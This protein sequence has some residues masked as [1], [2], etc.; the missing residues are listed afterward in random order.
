[1]TLLLGYPDR[2]SVAGGEPIRFMVSCEDS[3]S[4]RA[5]L[6]RLVHGDP[7]PDGPGFR[8]EEV[9]S[10]V[11]GEHR[12]RVQPIPIGSYVDVDDPGGLLDLRESFTLFTFV[13]PTLPGRGEQAL[14]GRWGEGG[15]LL[16][17]DA[18]GRLVLRVG[19]E[20]AADEVA[21]TEPLA[22]RVWYAVAATLDASTGKAAVE[23]VP[24]VNSFSSLVGPIAAPAATAAEGTVGAPPAGDGRFLLAARGQADGTVTSHFNGKLDRPRVYAR[25]LERSELAALGRLEEPPGAAPVAAWDFAEGIGPAGI[26][27]DRVADTTPNGLDGTCVNLPA[28]AM[29]GVNWSG[30]EHCFR[31]AAEEYGAIHFHE[32]D[33]EDACWEADLEL[34]VEPELPSGVYAVRLRADEAEEHIP[35]CVRPPRGTA[36]A[37]VAMLLPTAS[38]M[39]YMNDHQGMVGDL[40]QL[41]LAHTPVLSDTDL[42]LNERRDLGLSMYDSHHDGSGSCYSTRLR[43]LLTMRPRYL[44]PVAS[45]PWGF[46]SDLYLIDWLTST[47]APFDVVTDEDLHH[48]GLELLSRYRCVLTGSH[49][50]YTSH[51]MLDAL[52]AYLL[53]GGR[54]MYLG[55]DGFYWVTEYHPEKPHVIE[56][57][58]GT[59]GIR[60]WEGQPGEGHLASTGGA[61]GLWR[62]HGRAPQKLV[63]VGFAAE[64]MDESSYFRR[65]PDSRDPRAAWVFEGV[66]GETFGDHGLIQGGASGLELDRYDLSLGTPPETLLLAYSEGHTDQYLRVVEEIPVTRNGIGGTQDPGVRGDVVLFTTPGGGAVFSGSSIAWSASLSWNDYDNDVARIT[67]NVLERFRA[68]GPIAWDAP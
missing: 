37:D 30:R 42:L 22:R 52:E 43:P 5:D 27:S 16:T 44:S 18:A 55:G 33:L 13:W 67:G 31:H 2:I 26:P 64:G 39:A 25:A 56:I 45:A 59:S 41:I 12:G 4:Y 10:A 19:E 38:Y 21:T 50:E 53:E 23:A 63:G 8:E 1:M 28:R 58:R 17:L 54:L 6:V 60:T 49:P 47:R 32:D 15:Y 36:S 48:E 11:A 51:A 66:D 46:V 7:H 3:T 57:R 65:L 24:V 61:G 68:E 62:H 14:L 20:R 35:F 29:T 34:T 9:P 40:G